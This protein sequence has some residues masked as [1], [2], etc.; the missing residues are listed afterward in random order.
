MERPIYY[1][2]R[3]PGCAAWAQRLTE[4]EARAEL[5]AANRQVRGH[6]VV[7][8]YRNGRA[9]YIDLRGEACA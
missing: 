2:I 7:A 5:A 1:D 6:R 8:V 9:E 3:R 4:E